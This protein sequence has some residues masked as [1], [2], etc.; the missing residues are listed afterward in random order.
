MKSTGEV[1]GID[2]DFGMAYAKSQES[3]GNNL[4]RGGT[5]FISVRNS[6]RRNIVF[7]AR[8][9]SDLGFQICATEG[10]CRVLQSNGINAKMVEK[11]GEGKPD[12]VDL[13]KAGDIGFVINVPGG[14]KALMDSKPIRAAAVSQDIPYI[15]TLE[16]AQAAISGLHALSKRGFSVMSIQEYGASGAEKK[17]MTEDF[18]TRRSLFD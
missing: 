14:R 6:M 18:E 5:V 16:G 12:I 1:M 11:L 2:K 13:I 3:A 15:T 7:M 8:T 10:T 4:P 9:L 17:R